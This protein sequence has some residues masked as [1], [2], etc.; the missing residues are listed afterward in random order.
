MIVFNS[1][2]TSHE[3]PFQEA[4]M[5]DAVFKAADIDADKI[6]DTWKDSDKG[7]YDKIKVTNLLIIYPLT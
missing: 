4:G 2:P 5:I 1:S 3:E 7:I 6:R